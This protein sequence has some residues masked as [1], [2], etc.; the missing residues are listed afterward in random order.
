MILGALAKKQTFVEMIDQASL[1]VS[2]AIADPLKRTFAARPA[3]AN[4]G[5]LCEGKRY[6]IEMTLKN[7]D[8]ITQRLN[9]TQPLKGSA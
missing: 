5:P 4:F 9:V 6:R 7:E 1:M 8:S 3:A 2:A